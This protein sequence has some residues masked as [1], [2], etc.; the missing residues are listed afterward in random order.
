MVSLQVIKLNACGIDVGYEDSFITSIDKHMKNRKVVM[1]K[2]RVDLGAEKNY[3][4]IEV[5][6]HELAMELESKLLEKS[7]GKK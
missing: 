2:Y 4:L 5:F 6:D 1:F 3:E 7:D